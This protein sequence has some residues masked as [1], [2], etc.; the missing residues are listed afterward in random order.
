MKNIQNLNL[1][2]NVSTE[3]TLRG[4]LHGLLMIYET[5]DLDIREFSKGSFKFRS[6]FENNSRE[7]DSLQADDLAMMSTTAME[8]NW[9]NASIECLRE[10]IYL[11]GQ[12][13]DK[14]PKYHLL[15]DLN[16]ILLSKKKVYSN[17][18]N[19]MLIEK[20]KTLGPDW[21]LFSYFVDEG[22]F[23]KFTIGNLFS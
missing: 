23:L 8:A 12:C 18:H 3:R 7:S 10:S 6:G 17:S 22:V 11:Y 9:Y 20:R 16:E 19:K 2:Y 1:N 5:Y 15:P 14:K 13:L 21:R 4:A